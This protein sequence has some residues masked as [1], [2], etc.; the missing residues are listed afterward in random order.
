M[1]GCAGRGVP[2][3]GRES[4]GA[5]PRVCRQRARE[6]RRRRGRTHRRASSAAGD[7]DPVARLGPARVLLVVDHDVEVDDVAAVALEGGGS[8]VHALSL[9]EAA[10]PAG[11]GLGVVNEDVS[12]APVDGDEAEALL[13]VEPLHG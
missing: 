5:A 4:G 1:W 6:P 10:E 8:E 3:D 9:V 7:L 11:V 13:A 12:A 2:D